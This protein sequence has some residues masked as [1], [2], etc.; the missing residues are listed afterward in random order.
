M[1]IL[2]SLSLYLLLSGVILLGAA[3]AGWQRRYSFTGAREFALF[4]LITASYLLGYAAELTQER[5]ALL[6]LLARIEYV[7]IAYMP[8]FWLLFCFPYCGYGHLLGK[9]LILLFFLLSTV[10][11]LLYQTTSLHGLMYYSIEVDRSGG[12]P[13]LL[14]R[15]GPWYW[16]HF[17]YLNA[18]ILAGNVLFMRQCRSAMPIHRKQAYT[19]MLASMIPWL[20]LLIHVAGWGPRGIDFNPFGLSVTGLLFAWGLYRQQLLDFV[21]VARHELVERMRDPVLVFEASGRLI[22]HNRSACLFLDAGTERDTV[23]TLEVI[24]QHNQ[25]L[26]EAL[27]CAVQGGSASYRSDGRIFSL[28]M[29]ELE[30]GS[31]Q[32]LMLCL[33]Y[34]MTGQVHA[35]ERL[36]ALN[37]TL[38]QRIAQ[39]VAA[40]REKD[41]ILARQA[42]FAAMGEMIAVIAHQWRQPLTA[43]SAIMQNMKIAYDAGLLTEAFIEQSVASAQLQF[44]HMSDTIDEFRGF[45]R[46]EK[47]LEQVDVRHCIEE[48][49]ALFRHQLR[50]SLID[51]QIG[52]DELAPFHTRAYAGELKQVIL[53]LLSNSRDAII[54]RRVAE[55]S[56]TRQG[57]ISIILSRRDTYV[58]ME[59][60]DNGSGIPP[61][62]RDKI[63]DPYFT[64]RED[65][66]GTGLGLYTSRMIIESSM[67]GRMTLGESCDGGTFVI[68]LPGVFS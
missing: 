18:A 42:R 36:R 68:E 54:A 20:T 51:V 15:R 44:R 33:F 21:P 40:N 3:A 22:D 5:V 31:G 43:A 27:T 23:I 17:V 53:N 11:C 56:A 50:Y 41:Q 29:T 4:S 63:F 13:A 2:P 37:A 10:T 35:E 67:G 57:V 58:R 16:V 48:A 61:E 7:S 34:D 60:H 59:I 9:R 30:I 1:S 49:I 62:V 65:E 39:E 14:F 32:P 45:F 46:S 52:N 25:E 28:S 55:L 38:E 19:L 12:H 47:I 6:L 24:A 64:T 66:G 26:G 8:A